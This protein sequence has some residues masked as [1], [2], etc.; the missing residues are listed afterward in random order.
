MKILALIAFAALAACT[1]V[2]EDVNQ[3]GYVCK[4]GVEYFVYE[5]YAS[6]GV[7]YSVVPHFKPDGSLYTCKQVVK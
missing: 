1:N 6:G 2:Q 4:S 3:S 7:S 5:K